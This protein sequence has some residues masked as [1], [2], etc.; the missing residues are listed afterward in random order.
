MLAAQA[1]YTTVAGVLAGLRHDRRLARSAG[2]A[3][4]AALGCAVVAVAALEYALL[5]HD[6]SLV[7]V[8]DHTSRG[9][10]LVYTITSLWA[11]QPGSLLLWLTVLAACGA[12]V[13]YQNRNRNR[14]LMPWVTAVIGGVMVF[15]ASMTAFVSSPFEKVSGATP[16]AGLG[17]D[18]SLQNPYMAI[19][20]PMLYLGYVS[21]AVPFAFAMAALVTGRTTPDGCCPCAAGR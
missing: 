2:N 17:L 1:I 12:L 19:H 3:L 4:V 9:L 10:P 6:F 7:Q 16:T 5:T 11:S 21:C 14:E 15:F 13:T 18:P 20:P 8:V